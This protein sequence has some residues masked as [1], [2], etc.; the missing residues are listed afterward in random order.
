MYS[1]YIV[2]RTQIYVDV[3]QDIRLGRRARAAGVTKSMVIREAI[4]A[5]LTTPGAE[6]E[7][8]RFHAAIDEIERTPLTFEDGRSYVE[9]VRTADAARQAALDRRRK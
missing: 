4:E 9:R 8:D 7:L 5:Y 3:E 1:S 6:T 2:K